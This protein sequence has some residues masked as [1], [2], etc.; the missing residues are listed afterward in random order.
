MFKSKRCR[1]ILVDSRSRGNFHVECPLN[2]F[3]ISLNIWSLLLNIAKFEINLCY[4]YCSNLFKNLRKES[5]FRQYYCRN[6]TKVGERKRKSWR[7]KFFIFGNTI[8]EIPS[9]YTCCPSECSKCEC[10]Q[11]KP[12]VAMAL[13]T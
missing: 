2:C 8:T 3:Y 9:A 1:L 11:G 6:S 13:P 10:T 12:N 5:K 4:R 7:E